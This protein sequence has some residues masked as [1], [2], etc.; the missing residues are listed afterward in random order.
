MKEKNEDLKKRL[1]KMSKGYGPRQRIADLLQQIS[2]RYKKEMA[3][4]DMAEGLIFKHSSSDNRIVFYVEDQYNKLFIIELSIEYFPENSVAIS[5]RDHVD[6]K[7]QVETI[8]IET[9]ADELDDLKFLTTFL[10]RF[11]QIMA[12]PLYHRYPEKKT[13]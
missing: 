10:R 11:E 9:F 4:V 5:I 13:G 8:S 1:S 3:T 12:A 2:D 7:A 6:G